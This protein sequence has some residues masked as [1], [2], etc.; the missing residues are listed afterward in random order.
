LLSLRKK[1]N[2]TFFFAREQHVCQQTGEKKTEQ[3]EQNP[4]FKSKSTFT[5]NI[6]NRQ[7]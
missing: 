3:N 7:S 1:F 4:K 2:E 6:D 5:E